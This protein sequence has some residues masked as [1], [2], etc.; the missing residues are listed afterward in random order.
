MKKTASIL[1]LLINFVL[2]SFL[3]VAIDPVVGLS[4]AGIASLQ[5]ADQMNF[6][7]NRFIGMFSS[8]FPV[9][10]LPISMISGT[11]ITFI[12]EKAKEAI[13]DPAFDDPELKDIHT[14]VP[15]IVAD[16]QVAFMGRINKITRLDPGC[17][18]GKVTKAIPLS[19]KFWTPKKMKVWSAQ[20][21]DDLEQ[22]FFVW[23]LNKGTDRKDLTKGQ[24][25]KYALELM[26]EAV[27]SDA[28]R[29][30]W[31]G[32]TA[33]DTTANGGTL[34]NASDIA[35]YNQLD[36]FWKK[37]FAG[38]TGGTITK[39]YTIAANA[40][41]T[42]LLQDSVF[43]AA[44]DE[45]YKIVNALL[46]KAD[47]RL[48][49]AKGRQV[50]YMTDSVWQK[51]LTEKETKLL[52]MSFVR[53]GEFYSTD[54]YRGVTIIALHFWDRWIRA[55]FNDGTVSNL[56]HR[57]IYT[58]VENLQIGLD[59]ASITDFR[60]WYN[61]DTEETNW[62]GLYKMDVQIPHDFFVDAAF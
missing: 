48:V 23:G 5:F 26:T 7:P 35:N 20:C 55:D 47:K 39:A 46:K 53:Q 50:I 31:F 34:L 16:T 18:S 28:L 51:W 41:A 61:D 29:I 45:A 57:A 43:E 25:A 4:V 27:T 52:D 37:I 62:K 9:G 59:T 6:L 8:M 17:G 49:G 11:P 1:Q 44:T 13:I 12:K 19:E 2:A 40:Q 24:F 30:A 58:L 33:V 60:V 14:I 32:D 15:G 56:P 22:T 21:A 36:G 54:K 38:V 3:A 10:S 42:T